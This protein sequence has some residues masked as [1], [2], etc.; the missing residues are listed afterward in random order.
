MYRTL[1][2]VTMALDKIYTARIVDCAFF[3]T[4]KAITTTTRIFATLAT[5]CE[6]SR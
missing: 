1:L 6:F 3:M 4:R 5:L 2:F